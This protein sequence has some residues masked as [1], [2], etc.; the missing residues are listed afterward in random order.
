MPVFP[1]TRLHNSAPV[2]DEQDADTPTKSTE[3]ETSIKDDDEEH[4]RHLLP[5]QRTRFVSLKRVEDKAPLAAKPTATNMEPK[6]NLED[7]KCGLLASDKVQLPSLDSQQGEENVEARSPGS[8]VESLRSEDISL[9]L[10]PW[11]PRPRSCFETSSNQEEEADHFKKQAEA[12]EVISMKGGDDNHMQH[13]AHENTVSREL[14]LVK[15]DSVPA[16]LKPAEAEG[17]ST[18]INQDD[19]RQL[20]PHERKGPWKSSVEKKQVTTHS[21][22]TGPIGFNTVEEDGEDQSHLPPHLRKGP[23]RSVS[24]QQSSVSLKA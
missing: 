6:K 3:V 22:E 16:T 15:T 17:D 1:S 5:H 18:T 13:L 23:W 14:P 2:L 20:L 10:P 8:E 4:Q 21:I 19:Q 24:K 11:P 7:I 12:A 9:D